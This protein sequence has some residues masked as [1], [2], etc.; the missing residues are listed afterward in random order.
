MADYMTTE[1]IA[2]ILN[3]SKETIRRYIR[4]GLL[5]AIRLRGLYRVKREDFEEFVKQSEV[6][7]EE[8]E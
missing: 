7:P 2:K 8:T 1:E 3:V 5:P 4:D 6:R